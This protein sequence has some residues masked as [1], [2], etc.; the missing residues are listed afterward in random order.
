[1]LKLT[2]T[3]LP[4]A[5][6]VRAKCPKHVSYNPEITGEGGIV[7]ACASCYDLYLLYTAQTRMMEA[8][9]V[10][11]ERAERW[12]RATPRTGGLRRIVEKALGAI[13]TFKEEEAAARAATEAAKNNKTKAAV[14]SED[15]R[16]YA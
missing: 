12:E 6:R 13:R 16:E 5:E 7:A 1:M 10:Y 4:I 8:I 2:T 11:N 9:R 3:V 14:A 15:G